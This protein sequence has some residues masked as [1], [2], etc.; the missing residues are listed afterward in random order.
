V[1]GTPEG[2]I[3][4]F[5][6]ADGSPAWS[7]K[8]SAKSLTPPVA[9]NGVVVARSNDGK[10]YLLDSA[11]GKQRWS[12]RRTLAKSDLLREQGQLLMGSNAVLSMPAH[13]GGKLTAPGVG[14]R[15]ADMGSQRDAAARRH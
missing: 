1:V 8:L 5:K 15:R 3:S 13:A 10:V 7:A 9:A 4:G 2:S 11:S 6:S 14:Q 12:Y